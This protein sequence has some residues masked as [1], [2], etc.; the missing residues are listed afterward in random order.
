MCFWY[1]N[2][3]G[4]VPVIGTQPTWNLENK[5]VKKKFIFKYLLSYRIFTRY[6]YYEKNKL[7]TSILAWSTVSL[8]PFLQTMWSAIS[9]TFP[10]SSFVGSPILRRCSSIE[11]GMSSPESVFKSPFV[12]RTSSV[13]LAPHLAY[14]S[15]SNV[16]KKDTTSSGALFENSKPTWPVTN[17]VDIKKNFQFFF[18]I[19][20]QG[21]VIK[22]GKTKICCSFRRKETYWTSIRTFAKFLSPDLHSSDSVLLNAFEITLLLPNTN[23]SPLIASRRFFINWFRSFS[24]VTT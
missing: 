2:M 1:K 22:E 11:W 6:E 8:W 15:S 18:T 3:R 13:D 4:T 7:L 10:L 17:L 21:L 9:I 24:I 20:S 19:R 23:V 5:S 12:K 16:L 14:S